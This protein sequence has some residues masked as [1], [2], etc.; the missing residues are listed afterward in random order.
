M[1]RSNTLANLPRALMRIARALVGLALVAF[2]MLMAL[3]LGLALLLRAWAHGRR[4]GAPRRSHGGPTGAEV[5]DV[6]AREVTAT[7]TRLGR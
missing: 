6:E 4:P 1:N 2:T 5:V 3:L 7:S